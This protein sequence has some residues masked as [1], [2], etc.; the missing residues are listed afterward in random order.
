MYGSCSQYEV[1]CLKIKRRQS[2]DQSFTFSDTWFLP[3]DLLPTACY[4]GLSNRVI[5]LMCT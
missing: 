3:I 2:I 1:N 4:H 5:N